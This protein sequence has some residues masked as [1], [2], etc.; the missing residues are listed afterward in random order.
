MRE[1]DVFVLPSLEDSFG[2][3]VLEAMA[4]ALPVVVTD[5]VGASEVIDSGVTGVVVPAGDEAE[6]KSAI[7]RLADDPELRVRVGRAARDRVVTDRSWASYGTNALAAF[8][9]ALGGR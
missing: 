2:L 9:A 7:R 1:A 6:M 4:T 3:V 8:A 5:H